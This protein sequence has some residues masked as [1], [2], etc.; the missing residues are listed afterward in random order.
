MSPLIPFHVYGAAQDYILDDITRLS[1]VAG[2]CSHIELSYALEILILFLSL[3]TAKQIQRNTLAP[4]QSFVYQLSTL[5][6]LEFVHVFP[7]WQRKNP[8]KKKMVEQQT[9][10]NMR[11]ENAYV[12]GNSQHILDK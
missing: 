4:K 9:Y 7:P 3:G 6:C 12:W 11:L 10:Q 2:V 8:N 5:C 1:L